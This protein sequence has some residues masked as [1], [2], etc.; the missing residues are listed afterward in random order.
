MVIEKIAEGMTLREI[1]AS[2]GPKPS[3]VVCFK[4]SDEEFGKRYARAREISADVNFD[5]LVDIA[6]DTPAD[7]EAVQR[8]KLLI[9][10]HKWRLAKMFP[11][12]FGDKT[13][14][15]GEGGGPVQFQAVAT[16][17]PRPD[18]AGG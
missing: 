8:S 9:D 5:H 2:G 4:L 3:T 16:G 17:V 13:Q 14:I 6:R 1:E 18:D 15:T 10:A 12:K 11:A 7:G